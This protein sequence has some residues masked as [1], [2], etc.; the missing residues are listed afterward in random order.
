MKNIVLMLMM[1]AATFASGLD[2]S[3]TLGEAI[4]I[5]KQKNLEIKAAALD[6]QSA[7]EDENLIDA[8][9]WG[10][11]DF[12][13]DFARTND[14]GNVFGFK[15]TS[16]EANFGDFGAREFM[17][18][19]G[20]NGGVPPDSA[21]TTPPQDLNYPDDRNFFQSKLKYEVPLFTGF[22][23]TTYSEIMSEMSKIKS[24]EKEKLEKEKIYQLRKSYYNMALLDDSISNLTLI[25]NNINILEDM[26]KSMIDVGYAKHIDLLEVK[27]KKGNVERLVTQMNSNKKL[28]F[29]YISFLLNTSISEITTPLSDVAMPNLTDDEVLRQNLDIQRASTGLKIR[30]NMLKANEARYYPTVGAFGEIATADDTFLGNASDHFAYTVG[31]RLSW[32]LFNGGED[33]ANIEKAKIQHLKMLSQVELAKSGIALKLAKIRTEI[34]SADEEIA[35]LKKELE[36]SNA[37]YKNYEGRYKE[38]LSS[39]SDVIIKQSEQI[40]KILQLQIAKNRRNEK[41]FELENLANIK[42]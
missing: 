31:A 2:N 16:R 15:L 20:A 39:M 13:Q 7:K 40:E 36:F 18:A 6:I 10:K 24:L 21:Y 30:K 28:L 42:E 5:L 27:A 17:N 11:L 23:L 3:P 38:K 37:I 19:T 29:H 41:I 14:A 32:N 1:T 9:H 35:S 26:T 34:E 22:A 12:T 4:E 33:S 8:K 25:L